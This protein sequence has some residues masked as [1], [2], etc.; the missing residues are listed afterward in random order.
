MEQESRNQV[1]SGK[2]GAIYVPY[3]MKNVPEL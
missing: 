3:T 1:F 2:E